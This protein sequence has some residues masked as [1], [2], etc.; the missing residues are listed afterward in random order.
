MPLLIRF[1]HHIGDAFGH[2][3]LL[4]QEMWHAIATTKCSDP[5]LPCSLTRAAMIATNLVSAKSQDCYARFISAS[6]IRS[7]FSSKKSHD[8]FKKT[9]GLL[10]EIWLHLDQSVKDKRMDEI[11]AWAVFGR[12]AIRAC[13]WLLDMTM[14]EISNRQKIA[15]LD[16]VI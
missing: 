4:G 1:L 3:K 14:P 15:S 13:L 16:Y 12:S 7:K 8:K 5:N 6:T 11:S 10:L 2:N 9:E